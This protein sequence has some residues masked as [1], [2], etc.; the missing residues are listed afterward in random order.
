MEE[1]GPRREQRPR[2]TPGAVTDDPQGGG[3]IGQRRE[4]LPRSSALAVR[5]GRT[6][7]RPILIQ[8]ELSSPSGRAISANGSRLT[9]SRG[10]FLLACLRVEGLESRRN[11]KRF[12][13]HRQR[14]HGIAEAFQARIH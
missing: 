6:E 10:L 13:L 1:V 3:E 5:R 7:V 12:D 9:E 14:R 4:R 8:S 11:N 2:V